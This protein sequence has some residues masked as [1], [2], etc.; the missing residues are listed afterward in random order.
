MESTQTIHIKANLDG[1]FRRFS[2]QPSYTNL[3]EVVRAM[4]Q[5]PADTKFLLKYR[6]EED[7]LCTITTQLELDFAATQRTPLKL[8]IVPQPAVSLKNGDNPAAQRQQNR[9]NWINAK[10]QQPN[11]PQHKVD[12]LT[13]KRNILQTKMEQGELKSSRD[14][15]SW[16]E[17]RLAC[18]TA[19]LARPGLPQ[20]KIDCLTA[21]RDALLSKMAAQKAQEHPTE[22]TPNPQCKFNC[23]EEGLAQINAKLEQPGLP[24]PEIEML[25][26]KKRFLTAKLEHKKA[27]ETSGVDPSSPVAPAR[28]VCLETCL[29]NINA[30]LAA[31]GIP[32]KGCWT[33]I[34]LLNKKKEMIEAKLAAI[35]AKES[36][37]PGTPVTPQ[38]VHGG[39]LEDR[40][41]VINAELA[42][43]GL[44]QQKIRNLT[45]KKQ[46]IEN[47]IAQRNGKPQDPQVDVCPM[48]HRARFAVIRK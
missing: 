22:E 2:A 44:P 20:Q 47:L 48:R 29:A 37:A 12:H 35:K 30:K 27:K 4:F 5:I 25:E 19:Q 13:Q 7:D 1:Q 8:V 32:Q 28:R 39:H 45:M 6:D 34:E 33:H 46:R 18:L 23:L 16:F 24:Q 41:A 11:L 21:R 38:E 26:M 15:G 31:P 40:L 42:Q 17:K 3:M 9:L 10:L 36:S 43:P 14:C